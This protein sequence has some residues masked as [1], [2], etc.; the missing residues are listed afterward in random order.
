[1]AF[2]FLFLSC[3]G[4]VYAF[5]VWSEL[6]LA[7]FPSWTQPDLG[8]VY[9]AGIFGAFATPVGGFIYDNAGPVAT[10][11]AG[12]GLMAAGLGG[13]AACSTYQDMPTAVVAFFYYVEE[14]G[15]STLY[16]GILLD[17]LLHF[18]RGRI[19]LAAGIVS[20]GY[21]MAALLC[22]AVFEYLSP[23]LHGCLGGVGAAAA[24]MTAARLCM[25]TP[26]KENAVAAVSSAASRAEYWPA[27][28]TVPGLVLVGTGFLMKTPPTSLLGFLTSV[29][30]AARIDG[31][32]LFISTF[33][34]GTAGRILGGLW[35]DSQRGSNRRWHPCVVMGA[36]VAGEVLCF[37]G[38]AVACGWTALAAYLP[39]VVRVGCGGVLVLHG[40]GIPVLKAYAADAFHAQ[41]VGLLIGLHEMTIAVS[42]LLF[43]L[44]LGPA[45]ARVPADFFRTFLASAVVCA[46]TVPVLV[47]GCKVTDRHRKGETTSLMINAAV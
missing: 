3:L 41:V 39:V 31:K 10:Y 26:E 11:L 28:W 20:V 27:L 7:A 37:L 22:A 4:T 44:L 25:G 30:T 38:L 9:S 12:V 33:V 23:T 35:F 8:L 34:V 2:Y 18:P 47:K 14:Q 15:S 5:S 17:I 21:A 43:T 45:A 24:V 32:S 46:L 36:L 29:G 1:M 6:L 42:N 13:I 19:A 16:M 40:V